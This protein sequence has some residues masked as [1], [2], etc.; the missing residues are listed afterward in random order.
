MDYFFNNQFDKKDIQDTF[1]NILHEKLK[2]YIQLGIL[3]NCTYYKYEIEKCPKEQIKINTNL[4]NNFNETLL[5]NILKINNNLKI[6]YDIK[7]NIIHSLLLKQYNK[8][9][10]IFNKNGHN[11]IKNLYK[12]K[13]KCTSYFINEF[14]IIKCIHYTQFGNVYYCKNIFNNKKY[15]MKLFYLIPCLKYNC[16]YYINDQVFITNYFYKILNEIFFLIYLKNKNI[17]H[18][19]KIFWDNKK[20]TICIFLQYIK[21]QS[22]YFKKKVGFYSIYKK[23]NKKIYILEKN[24][25]NKFLQIQLYSENF[26]KE[27]FLHIYKTLI[28]LLKKNV[29][30]HDLKPDNILLNK[31]ILHEII[32]CTVQVKN[33]RKIKNTKQKEITKKSNIEIVN[34]EYNIQK[35]LTN[36]SKK[37]ARNDNNND[38]INLYNKNIFGRRKKEEDKENEQELKK[39]KNTK[40]HFYPYYKIDL[41]S[42]KKNK[43]KYI[44]NVKLNKCLEYDE[45]IKGIFFMKNNLS[46]ICFFSSY[47]STVHIQMFVKKNKN[48]SHQNSDQNK[49]D[50]QKS[51]YNNDKKNQVE[52]MY[53]IP[54]EYITTHNVHNNYEINKIRNMSI[55]KCTPKKYIRFLKFYWIYLNKEDLKKQ[56]VDSFLIYLDLYFISKYLNKIFNSNNILCIKQY[57]NQKVKKH[58]N[59]ILIESKIEHDINKKLY[60]NNN[61]E[62][63]FNMN[64]D[65]F[66][67][68]DFDTCSFIS[69]NC[70]HPGTNIFSPYEALFN[71]TNKDINYYKKLSYNFGSVLYTFVYGKS[72][73]YGKDIFEIF[74]NMQR[75]LKFPK[76]RKINKDLRNLLR[77]LLKKNQDERIQFKKIIRHKWFINK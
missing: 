17:V 53:N 20:K 41:E 43:I 23:N 77:K 59:Q 21:Y 39:K 33:K 64:K 28:S 47:D 45:N 48:I 52:H 4:I 72:P 62:N 5:L 15:C 54:R 12:I 40:V 51:N 11:I 24:N 27:L 22:M 25:K 19:E 73:Y 7:Y 34:V 1:L 31:R 14:L 26:I 6:Y 71:V 35:K 32:T 9:K 3:S 44:Y 37:R 74:Q 61:N 76:Y 60:N 46:K 70:N 56:N 55:F 30:Y 10:V 49:L 65:F 38:I 69:Q 57:Q 2:E 75:R 36:I 68:I 67:L 66:K 29:A 13:K 18:I 16:P 63:E 58:H 8:N 50:E 42:I